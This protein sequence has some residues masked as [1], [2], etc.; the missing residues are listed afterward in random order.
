MPARLLIVLATS[1]LLVLA[2]CASGPGKDCA[3]INWY[4]LGFADGAAGHESERFG[5]HRLACD[6]EA[7]PP[8][9][10]AWQVGYEDGLTHFCSAAGG[11]VEGSEGRQR[12]A[13]C[14]DDLIEEF[15]EGYRLGREIYAVERRMTDI[16][17]EIRA[18]EARAAGDLLSPAL[19]DDGSARIR[20][21]EQEYQRLERELRLLELRADRLTRQ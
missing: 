1:G 9:Q 16:E 15:R 2:G 18:L 20:R 7:G 17:R 5:Q 21:L 4:E 3:D 11:L 13:V 10:E 6:S 14:P 12:R 19:R 8:D